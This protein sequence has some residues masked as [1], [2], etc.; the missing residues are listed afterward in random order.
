MCDKVCLLCGRGGLLHTHHI[1]SGPYRK[2]STKYGL[3]VPLCMACHTGPRG[4]HSDYQ[5]NLILKRQAQEEFEETHG[6]DEFR[7]IFG[8]SYIMEDEE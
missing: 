5:L 3:V 2:A 8:K 7:R 6:R 4:V 1:F